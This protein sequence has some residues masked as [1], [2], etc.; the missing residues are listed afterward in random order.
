MGLALV[1]KAAAVAGGTVQLTSRGRGCVFTVH[2][3]TPES[4]ASEQRL[5]A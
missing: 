4:P 3:P 1:E 2:L 5:S